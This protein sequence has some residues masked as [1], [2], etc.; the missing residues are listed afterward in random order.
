MYIRYSDS[1][2]QLGDTPA[3]AVV[4]L[5]APVYRMDGVEKQLTSTGEELV[6]AD[7]SNRVEMEIRQISETLFY[8]K[9]Y[10]KNIPNT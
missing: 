7:A 6:Y 2:F 3:D 4:C 1:R 10:W 8:I 9:R 5:E